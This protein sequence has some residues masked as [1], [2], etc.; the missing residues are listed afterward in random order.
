MKMHS[1]TFPEREFFFFDFFI[2][3]G[4]KIFS[5]VTLKAFL[6]SLGELNLLLFMYLSTLLVNEVPGKFFQLPHQTQDFFSNLNF[7]IFFN[8][9]FSINSQKKSPSTNRR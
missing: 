6:V 7:S 4:K 5:L 3:A 8:I 2:Q 1:G 9:T